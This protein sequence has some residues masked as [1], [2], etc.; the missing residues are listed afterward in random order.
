MTYAMKKKKNNYHM[1]KLKTRLET[2]SN[3]RERNANNIPKEKV[4]KIFISISRHWNAPISMR[5]LP[6]SLWFPLK[7]LSSRL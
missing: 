1:T 3:D 6:K 5:K 2:I 7:V 4:I